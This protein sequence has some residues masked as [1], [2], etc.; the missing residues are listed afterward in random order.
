MKVNKGHIF[1]FILGLL[2][3]SGISIYAYKLYANQVGYEPN[4]HNWNV[5]D[6][7][8]ALDNLYDD[9][10]YGN[11][12]SS[13]IVSGKT[14]LVNGSQVTGSLTIPNYMTKSGAQSAIS[15]GGTYSLSN[16]YYQMTNNF[17][18]S[19]SSCPACNSCCPTCNGITWQSTTLD[20]ASTTTKSVT[21]GHYYLALH[22][23]A[24][25]LTGG[26]TALYTTQKMGKIRSYASYI[27]LVKATSSSLT[28]SKDPYLLELGY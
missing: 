3:S 1:A 7:K 17:S 9:A 12:T 22:S 23:V 21:N 6:V 13:D 11:A 2:L 20:T 5:S 15:P 16:G 28:F 10:T 24:F 18:V 26:G 14:A 25:T 8:E 27:V 19:C 4:N